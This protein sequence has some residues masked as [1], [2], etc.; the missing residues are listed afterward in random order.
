MKLSNLF[1][2]GWEELGIVDPFQNEQIKIQ[3]QFWVSPEG[4][5]FPDGDHH[6]PI[7]LVPN[8][9][10]APKLLDRSNDEWGTAIEFTFNYATDSEFENFLNLNVTKILDKWL[11]KHFAT[12]KQ[13]QPWARF[14][15][16]ANREW[17]DRWLGFLSDLEGR[18]INEL[19]AQYKIRT[20]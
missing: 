6:G 14:E 13:V 17:F 12:K 7:G 11:D 16:T 3:M 2:E 8:E 10:G 1:N 19:S 15:A 20:N 4:F 9:Y 5:S 18:S